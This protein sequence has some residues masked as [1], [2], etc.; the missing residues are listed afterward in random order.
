[1]IRVTFMI[2][3]YDTISITRTSGCFNIFVTASSAAGSLLLQESAVSRS[4]QLRLN[5][6]RGSKLYYADTNHVCLGCF[7]SCAA[8]QV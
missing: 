4:G 5:V 1:M 2:R 7:D 8:G 3:Y 6:I